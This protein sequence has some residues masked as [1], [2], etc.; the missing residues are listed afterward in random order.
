MIARVPLCMGFLSDKYFKRLPKYN[1]NDFRSNIKKEHSDWLVNSVRKL[2]FLNKL[3]GGISTSAIR[4]CLSNNKISTVI[5]GMRN[6][7]QV[8]KNL[9]AESL[10]P[11]NNET[12]EKIRKTIDGVHPDW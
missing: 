4:F 3:E 2:E 5:P 10:N 11:L 8:Q 7:N 12:L 6:I 9:F 1:S